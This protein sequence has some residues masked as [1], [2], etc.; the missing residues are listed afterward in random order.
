M[1]WAQ[2]LDMNLVHKSNVK[3]FA[4]FLHKTLNET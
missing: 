3:A 4:S 2:I 1:I